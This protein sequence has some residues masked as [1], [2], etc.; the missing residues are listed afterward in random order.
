MKKL[1]VLFAACNFVFAVG[2]S[3]KKQPGEEYYDPNY[4]PQANRVATREAQTTSTAVDNTATIAGQAN[5]DT[6]ETIA[7]PA[8]NMT[9]TPTTE[10]PT[11]AATN[12]AKDEPTAAVVKKDAL[13]PSPAGKSFD[14]GKTL[15]SKS[16]C[17]ACHKDDVKLLGPAYV[18]VAKKYEPTDKNIDYLVNKIIKGGSGVWGE[19]PMSPHP[20]LPPAD[21][22][23]MVQ[24][25]LSL[26]K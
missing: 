26:N 7:T 2:C 5:A 9:A 22:K 16:D 13:K 23:E 14:K 17:L 24:Y 18:D 20:N 25:I 19:I 8:A 1:F 11:T 4:K 6:T 12:P 15:I 21:A 10:A 3:S